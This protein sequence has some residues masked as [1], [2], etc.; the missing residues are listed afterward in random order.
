[1]RLAVPGESVGDAFWFCSLPPPWAP[2]PLHSPRDRREP[3]KP[4]THLVLMLHFRTRVLT[5]R[6]V[7]RSPLGGKSG[8]S[9]GP[10]LLFSDGISF[11]PLRWPCDLDSKRHL[12]KKPACA[13]SDSSDGRRRSVF[14]DFKAVRAPTETRIPVWEGRAPQGFHGICGAGVIDSE[15][16]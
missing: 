6:S 7:L 12:S 2:Q 5:N 3:G 15:C 11:S 10:C 13:G 9:R 16:G 4:P 1:M 14:S 8:S